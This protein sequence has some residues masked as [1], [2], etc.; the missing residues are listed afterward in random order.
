MSTL[1][2][3]IASD[4]LSRGYASMSDLQVADS[5]NDI[6]RTRNR[7][8]MTASEVM[9][10]INLA[11]FGSLTTTQEQQIWDVLHIGEI[12]P[13]GVEATIFI[14]LFGGGSATIANLQLAR[15][16]SISRVTELGLGH[17]REG[18]VTRARI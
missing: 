14:N 12:N 9:N 5:L 3:E 17:V 18:T 8:T 15:V 6:T 4:P 2:D 13:F 7:P 1:K 11:E 10:Q 16:E